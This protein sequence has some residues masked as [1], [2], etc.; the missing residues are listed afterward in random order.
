MVYDLR[1]ATVFVSHVVFR[2]DFIHVCI[3]FISVALKTV[4]FTLTPRLVLII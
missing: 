3:V 4:T 1:L 2:H